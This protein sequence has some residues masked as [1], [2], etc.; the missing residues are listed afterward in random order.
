MQ[1]LHRDT[2]TAATL[3]WALAAVPA[4][5]LG[6]KSLPKLAK[7]KISP[8]APIPRINKY[9][10]SYGIDHGGGGGPADDDYIQPVVDDGGGM[11]P[12]S[13][14]DGF[15]VRTVLSVLF[16]N[17]RA[18]VCAIRFH[19]LLL[20][21][22]SFFLSFDVKLCVQSCL[23]NYLLLL[24]LLRRRLSLSFSLSFSSSFF[25]HPFLVQTEDSSVCWGSSTCFV[26]NVELDQRWHGWQGILDLIRQPDG[27]PRLYADSCSC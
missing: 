1:R 11:R 2:R 3:A 25:V 14:G 15:Y 6:V 27:Q 21:L 4:Q 10:H 16:Y 20:V 8:S 19:Y 12:R 5:S 7:H 23:L 17:R 18:I 24:L 22:L 13:G 26:K 9:T